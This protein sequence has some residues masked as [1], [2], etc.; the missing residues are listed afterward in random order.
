MKLF[1]KTWGDV[2]QTLLQYYNDSTLHPFKVLTNLM[3]NFLSYY[4]YRQN[5]T[6]ARKYIYDPGGGQRLKRLKAV[7]YTLSIAG[8]SASLYAYKCHEKH[9][10]L[11]QC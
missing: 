4:V 7:I 10:L 5:D 11:S 9:E 2:R 8:A 1:L 6:H 3:K